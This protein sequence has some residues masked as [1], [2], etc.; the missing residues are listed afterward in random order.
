[1]CQDHNYIKFDLIGNRPSISKNVSDAN[2]V[3]H[4]K[5]H[6]LLNELKKPI[7]EVE[8]LEEELEQVEEDSHHNCHHLK[9][10]LQKDYYQEKNKRMAYPSN[11]DRKKCI[12]R[13]K[14]T[15]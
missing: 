10:L 2:I 1:M 6:Q 13:S 5:D 12:C 4:G 11:Q 7:K 3:D 15:G 9:K 14:L 8:E